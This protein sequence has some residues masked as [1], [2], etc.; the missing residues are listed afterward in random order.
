MA[1]FTLKQLEQMR[2][3]EAQA[4]IRS[5]SDADLE[6]ISAPAPDPVEVIRQL[7]DEE[8]ER[9][10]QL[11]PS[12]QERALGISAAKE[13]VD[14]GEAIGGL[15]KFSAA[16]ASPGM[17]FTEKGRQEAIGG[18][19][20]GMRALESVTGAPTRAAVREFQETGEFGRA[21]GAAREQ[22]AAAPETAPTGKDIAARAGLSTE[23]AFRLPGVGEVSPAGAAGLAAE[24]ILDPTTYVG[25]G[26]GKAIEKTGRGLTKAFPLKQNADDIVRAAEKLGTKPTP[27]QLYDSQLVGKLESALLQRRGKLGGMKLRKTVDENIKTLQKEADSLINEASGR[28][29]IE[30]G[31][32][33]KDQIRDAVGQK[34]KNASDLYDEFEDVYS[35][36]AA[37]IQPIRDSLDDLSEK[38]A[39]TPAIAK[40]KKW[41]NTIDK[42]SKKGKKTVRE[43]QVKT[44][45]NLKNFRT[46]VGNMSSSLDPVD[47][48]IARNLWDAATRSRSKSLI[49]A[50]ELAAD[51]PAGHAEQLIR[52]ADKQYAQA[53]EM[54]SEVLPRGRK[55]KGGVKKALDDFLDKNTPESMAETILRTGDA[56]R[57]ASFKATFPEAFETLRMGKI[58]NLLAKA[59]IKG[60]ISPQKLSKVI[61]NMPQETAELLLGSGAKQKAAAM[62]TYLN[63][64][65]EKINPS[66]TAEMLDLIRS[67]N[68]LSQAGSIG[69]S[70]LLRLLTSGQG[71][72]TTGRAV[73][74]FA[75]PA[76]AV[77]QFGREIN[78]EPTFGIPQE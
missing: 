72:Q 66:G 62:R 13:R 55:V 24:I 73:Q 38:Y 15:G 42:V 27:G 19:L 20:G 44:I 1:Q 61:D 47:R 2:P 39:G 33:A 3:E 58:D 12:Q 11:S 36:A 70:G 63:S 32:Q 14:F 50:A 69:Q 30:I 26:T 6:A 21:L 29:S 34:L 10:S 64:L 37:D 45:E 40:I 57:I 8:L 52:A 22:F 28:S 31:A 49:D 76:G 65:P 77:Q 71:L 9:L 23:P 60:E 75:L 46:S 18:L 35:K 5:M 16:L 67:F 7:P 43:Q 25:F 4:A 17:L 51:L 48:D 56:E 53:A 54:V 68:V 41:Q 78:R 59:T 74:Q